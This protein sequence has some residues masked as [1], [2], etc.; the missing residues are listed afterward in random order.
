MDAIKKSSENGQDQIFFVL[1]H[2]FCSILSKFYFCKEDL[3]RG[4]A[5]AHLGGSP[6]LLM[7]PGALNLGLFGS[8]L[9][10]NL[11]INFFFSFFNFRCACGKSNLFIN[12]YKV[13]IIMTKFID[14]KF[15]FTCGKTNW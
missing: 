14:I 10:S 12:G 15:P 5:P 7:L 2:S 13:Q 4:Y 9:G 8:C 6:N 11:Y 3:A 1:L